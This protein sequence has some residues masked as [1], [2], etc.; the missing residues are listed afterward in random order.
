MRVNVRFIIMNAVKLKKPIWQ[1]G[2]GLGLLLEMTLAGSAIIHGMR[3]SRQPQAS[4]TAIAAPRV[5][6]LGRLEPVSEILSIATPLALEGDRLAELSVKVGDAVKTGQVL[7]VLDSRD[8]LEKL[9]EQA[10]EQVQIAE[11]QLAQVK[12]G[13]KRGEI[14][15]QQ[16]TIAQLEAE[17]SGETAAQAATLSKLRAELANAQSEFDRYE[18]L[19]QAGAISASEQAAKRLTLST[20]QAQLNEAEANQNRTANT[21]QAQIEAARATLNQIAEVRPEDIAVAQAE[22]TRATTAA[23][24]AAAELD[25]AFVRSP[26]AGQVLKVL[27]RPGEKI[28]GGIV[29]LGQTEEMIVVAEVDES[30]IEKI[31]IGQSASVTGSAFGKTLQGQVSEIAQAVSKQSVFSNQPG[32]NLDARVVE[33]RVALTPQSSQMVKNLANLQVQ[34]A[35]ETGE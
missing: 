9:A 5:V 34:V 14:A 8:R 31:K 17:L 11:S 29:E 33:V 24:V 20:A 6:A 22:V 7:A 32:A 4:P 26:T 18:S 2:L 25:Q 27:V 12:A 28:E 23:K 16:A 1:I 3:Q 13:A 21:L 35:I 10:Q 30:D 19:Y 15:A